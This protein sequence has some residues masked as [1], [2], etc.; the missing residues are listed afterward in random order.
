VLQIK[1]YLNRRLTAWQSLFVVAT[2]AG[3]ACL[4]YFACRFISAKIFQAK[5][6]AALPKVCEAIRKERGT[7]LSAIEA[8]KAHFGFY[9]PD[10][11]AGGG[12]QIANAVTNP[13]LYELVGAVLNPASE[14]YELGGL[15]PAEAKFV[16]EFLN[17]T[18]F[19][20]SGS[21]TGQ[22]VRFLPFTNFPAAQLHDDPDVFAVGFQIFWADIPPETAWEFGISTWRYV[23]SGATHNPGKFDLWIEVKTSSKTVT[24]GN[25]REVE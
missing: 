2:I 21:T 24:I 5:V 10:S 11:A 22:V 3:V 19:V 1:K 20:N 25:W 14:M 4:G 15:E 18:G 8:Y 16:R 13:L 17:T 12:P 23:R 7:V 9:P 6:E